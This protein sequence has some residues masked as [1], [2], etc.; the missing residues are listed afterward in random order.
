MSST[1]WDCKTKLFG[2]KK[3]IDLFQVK[4]YNCVILL[5]LFMA[6][7]EQSLKKVVTLS[8]SLELC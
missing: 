4:S 6:K 2:V 5:L 1:L 7:V 8:K 3:H